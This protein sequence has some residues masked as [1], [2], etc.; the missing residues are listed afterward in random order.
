[1]RTSPARCLRSCAANR[2]PNEP[3][4]PVMRM[5]A[6]LSFMS[7]RADSIQSR[8]MLK[9]L[10]GELLRRSPAARAGRL[11]QRAWRLR[12]EGDDAAAVQSA[13]EAL[14]LWPDC[15]SAHHLLAAAELRGENYLTLLARLHRHLQPRTYLEIGV[16][17]GESLALAGPQTDA[18]GVDPQPRLAHALGPRTRV[19]AETSDEFFAK[20]DLRGELGGRPVELAFIDGMHLFEFVLRDFTNVES[21]CSRQGAILLHD[22]Y[23][24]DELTA[25][26]SRTTMFSSGDAWRAVLA[27][28]KYRPDL[29]IATLAAPPT[30]LA[31]VRGLDPS[32]RVLRERYDDIV[33]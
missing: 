18:V 10:L 33:I 7:V 32:S 21:H 17:T 9:K 31:V 27:L 11:A 12:R 30:G 16:S 5:T 8:R 22:C 3:V 19:F 25:A 6:R 28:K 20:R 2:L 15:L 23:P 26:R 29:R 24:L 13:R 4:P 14:T 1:M